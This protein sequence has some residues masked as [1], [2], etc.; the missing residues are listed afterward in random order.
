VNFSARQ[1]ADESVVEFIAA[2]L[3]ECG[4][5]PEHLMLEVTESAVLGDTTRAE[6]I[7]KALKSTGLRLS[8]DDFGTGYSSL[9]YLRRFP[10]DAIK[11]DRSFVL[12]MLSERD[13]ETIVAAVLGLADH[14][15][16]V[17]VAE[18]VESREQLE[19]LRALGC[20]YGQGFLW[21]PAVPAAQFVA[22]V[23][24]ARAAPWVPRVVAAS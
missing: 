13:D 14:L 20:A 23:R 19:R 15:G 9:S 12:G 8:I 4:L 16:L 22:E 18:G 1:L 17:A 5:E 6:R 2:V 3:A 24:S 21:S 7:L 11:L 10:V